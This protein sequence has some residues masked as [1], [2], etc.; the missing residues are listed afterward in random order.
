M[1]IGH[2]VGEL[3]QH[4]RDTYWWHHRFWERVGALMP[5]PGGQPAITYD[6]DILLVLDG[7]R[8]DMFC[9]AVAKFPRLRGRTRR[10]Y[11]H[12]SASDEWIRANFRDRDLR[13]MVAATANP[14]YET[15]LPAGTFAEIDHVWRH[16]WDDE[17]GTVRAAPVARAVRDLATRHPYNR[18]VGHFMQPHYPFVPTP[19]GGGG[20]GLRGRADGDSSARSDRPVWARGLSGEIPWSVIKEGYRENLKYVLEA[21]DELV[22]TLNAEQKIVITADHGNA[23]GERFFGIPVAGHPP[24]LPIASLRTVPWHRVGERHR[25][26]DD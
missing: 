17:L 25:I 12:G 14:Y 11:S 19:L 26:R 6:W 9:E 23:F 1:S 22:A 16:S 2:A 18:V 21:V 7:C 4:W 15:E 3:R 8:Y 10:H 13:Q 5:D 20:E 24:N